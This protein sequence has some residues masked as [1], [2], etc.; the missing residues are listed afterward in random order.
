M[1]SKKVYTLQSLSTLASIMARSLSVRIAAGQYGGPTPI[2]AFI[3]DMLTDQKA[4]I[5]RLGGPV[6]VQ[7]DRNQVITVATLIKQNLDRWDRLNREAEDIWQAEG[8]MGVEE[9]TLTPALTPE[10]VR[11]DNERAWRERLEEK[12]AIQKYEAEEE[13]RRMAYK[14]AR[15]TG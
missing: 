15:E 13:A 10:Q 6:L 1:A 14:F 8:E 5:D 7:L 12:A 3:N 2:R 11:R 4:G 9:P